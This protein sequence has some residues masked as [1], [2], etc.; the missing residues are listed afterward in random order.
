MQVPGAR[1]T[2]H[3]ARVRGNREGSFA[4]CTCGF[5]S[6]VTASVDN[7][8]LALADH[9]QRAVRGGAEVRYEGDGGASGVREPRRP[10]QPL[11]SA[12]APLDD[13]LNRPA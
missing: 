6:Q 3:R 2:G 4:L 11:G 12:S 10:L 5:Q 7:S 9:L 1:V 8:C 13:E